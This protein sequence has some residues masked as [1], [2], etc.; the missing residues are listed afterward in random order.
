MKTFFKGDK[1]NFQIIY[2]EFNK[3]ECSWTL[4]TI[5][6]EKN[7]CSGIN[8]LNPVLSELDIDEDTICGRFENSSGWR[9]SKREMKKFN[10]IAKSI[11]TSEK[12]LKYLENRLD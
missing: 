6:K 8:N 7:C 1:Y 2:E 9:V 3:N 4:K 5:C 12:Y 10:K 11:L